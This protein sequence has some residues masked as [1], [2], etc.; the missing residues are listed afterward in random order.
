M[1]KEVFTKEG[2]FT[3]PKGTEEAG[4]TE[5]EQAAEREL[6][7]WKIQVEHRSWSRMEGRRGRGWSEVD[8]PIYSQE[9]FLCCVSHASLRA[10][11]KPCFPRRYYRTSKWEVS[12]K[13]QRWMR[14]QIPK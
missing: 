6:P 3:N 12:N 8:T 11:D 7:G 9:P 13:P 1:S 10:K 14:Y 2:T 4:N 5:Q